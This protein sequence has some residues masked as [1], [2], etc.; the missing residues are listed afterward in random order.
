M[1]SILELG[2]GF[3]PEF[4]GRQNIRINAALLGL[5]AAR[6][7]ERT[8]A[9]VEFCELGDYIDQPVKSYSTGMA[10]RLAFSIATQVEPDVLIVDEALSVGDGYFQKKCIDRILELLERG[11][12]L[13]FCSHAMYYVDAFC[14]HAIWLRDGA[15]AAQGDAKLVIHAYEDFLRAR[16]GEAR[17][18]A[19]AEAPRERERLP[20]R[21][22]SVTVD[23]ESHPVVVSRGQTLRVELE[24]ESDD[25][26]RAFHVGVGVNRSDETEVLTLTT[27]ALGLPPFSGQRRYAGAFSVPELPL[28][29]GEFVVY[30]FLLDERMVHVY[31]RKVLRPAFRMEC[32][33]YEFA[34]VELPYHWHKLESASTA[35]PEEPPRSDSHLASTRA[36]PVRR[37][38]GE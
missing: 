18:G 35:S 11:T 33:P 6:V 36:T 28:V 2:A 14:R 15:V 26:E 30:A 10:M 7:A 3:H 1:S 24:W 23:G 20:A 12:T 29:K 22:R 8:P 19:L 21:F 37:I 34:L 32:G 38:V 31:D 4:T 9:I 17:A 13:L 25:P 27:K 5:D 16:T